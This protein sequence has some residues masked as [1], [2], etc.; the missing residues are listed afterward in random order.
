MNGNNFLPIG[1]RIL[2]ALLA[3][4]AFRI[5]Y[6]TEKKRSPELLAD[7]RLTIVTRKRTNAVV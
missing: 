7:F 3:G 5:L 2:Y 1:I 4:A 6:K